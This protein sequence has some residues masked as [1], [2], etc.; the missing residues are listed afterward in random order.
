[1]RRSIAGASILAFVAG[2]GL[3]APAK[4]ADEPRTINRDGHI[5][6]HQRV[7]QTK[8]KKSVQALGPTRSDFDGDGFDDIAASASP[9]QYTFPDRPNGLVVVQYSSAPQIDYLY[10][11]V[12]PGEAV[13][14]FGA[15]L[16]TGDFNGD[17]YHDLAIGV[18]DEVDPVNGAQAGGVWVVPGSSVGLVVDSATYFDQ[19]SPG[20]PGGSE[21]RDWF[22]SALAA[23]DING[24]GLDDLAIGAYGE[25]I[26]SKSAAGSVT[27][28]FGSAG[29]LT[30]V[31]AQDV[32]QDQAHVPGA[33]ESNDSFGYSL[34]IG[35]VDG[36]GY[37]DLAIGG[38]REN[39]NTGDDGSGT[40]V[41]MRGSAAGVSTSGA[42]S[43]N[44]WG[45]KP[46]TGSNDTYAWTLGSALAI[47]DVNGDGLGEVVAGAP[48][49]QTPHLN[50][51]LIAVF[52]GRG[53]G[54]ADSAVRVIN[55]R[56][57][58][59]PGEPETGDRFG[60]TLATGDV[61]GDGVAD[62][63]VGTPGEAIGSAA[64]AGVVTLL[65]GATGGISGNGAQSFDQNHADIPGGAEAGDRFGGAVA[66]LNLDGV[67]G[68]DAVVAAA[69]ESVSGDISDHSSGSI[70]PLFGSG[71][72][73][74]PQ[75]L[76]INGLDLRT[77]FVWPLDYGFEIAGPQGGVPMG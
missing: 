40:V 69:G 58:G 45:I 32:Y 17:G 52:T 16:A 18:P 11:V 44:G 50:G 62:V 42:T 8:A 77:D 64:G 22:G 12:A 66:L 3:N 35:P 63:L 61:T 6:Q 73:L 65:K 33:S 28:L 19:S 5:L 55:Q 39:E 23:G 41:L 59:V 60:A 68:L 48:G 14:G 36:D 25:S 31:G 21:N 27:V 4:A 47:G 56:T 54:I 9:F 43:V 29:G 24:D 2:L 51:G 71:G 1:M 30:D 7:A 10:S 75:P 20:I 13:S 76:S 74:V 57:A 67:D 15:A 38:P 72:G 26:G 34:A 49:A 37:A 70:Y 46:S 53:G